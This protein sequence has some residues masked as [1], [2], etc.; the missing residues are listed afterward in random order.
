MK[1]GVLGTGMVGQAIATKL[2][3]LGHDVTMG[4]RSAGNEKA[5]N[6]AAAHGG[7]AGS[8]ADA[9]SGVEIVFNCTKGETALD[10]LDAA[11]A[12]NLAGKVLVD[13][14]NPLDFSGGFPPSLSICNTDSLAE[15]I[16][17][18]FPD[19]HVVKALNTMN[20]EIMVDPARLPGHHAVFL[21]GYDQAAKDRVID[22]LKTFGWRDILDLGD[23][24]AARGI[25]MV[26][27]L[28]LKIMGR[29]GTSEF[30]FAITRVE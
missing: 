26:L 19:A 27:P 7:Q 15:T 9:A 6:W 4:A 29:L 23:L 20:C 28:W 10:A 3:S 5:A 16:Q 30:N 24:T 25:E 11:G 14:S 22:L 2:A 1:I 12:D 8:F 18:R 21:C 13:V 17:R